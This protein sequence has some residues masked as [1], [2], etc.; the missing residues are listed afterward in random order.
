MIVTQ[1]NGSAFLIM[2]NY[3]NGDPQWRQRLD[4]YL[5]NT[6]KMFF[7]EQYGGQIMSEYACESMGNCNK[8]QCSF[9]AYISRW[10][11]LTLQMAPYTA[12]QI[13]PWL[14]GSA[15]AAV[16][17][18]VAGPGGDEIGG[19]VA[20]GRKWYA[21]QDD[22]E[23]DVGN[24]MRAMSIVQANLIQQVAAHVD[25]K[26]GTS[27]GDSSAGS[28]ASRALTDTQKLATRR[29]TASDRF[30]AAIV[31]II[32]LL[33]TTLFLLT[34]LIGDL[35]VGKWI[36]SIHAI[37]LRTRWYGHWARAESEAILIR[38]RCPT[39]VLQPCPILGPMS[40]GFDK[41]KGR[42]DQFPN[43]S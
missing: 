40:F 37:P 12:W 5:G 20:C 30:G 8:D 16:K 19:P 42:L 4:N 25:Y 17:Q 32:M 36:S 6:Q 23:R 9:K 35:Q 34:L 7:P 39:A 27:T 2:S 11:A 26:T 24:Q 10:L 21:S 31:T 29:M 22:V 43:T 41:S 13:L 14:Q 3:T 15:Q 38:L 28:R 18:C 33:A 1:Y